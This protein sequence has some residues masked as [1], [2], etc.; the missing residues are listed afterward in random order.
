[1]QK[2]REPGRGGVGRPAM[3]IPSGKDGVRCHAPHV[4]R[5]RVPGSGPV[6]RRPEAGR[7]HPWQRRFTAFGGDP[8]DGVVCGESVGREAGNPSAMTRG[9]DAGCL[10]CRGLFPCAVNGCRNAL[11]RDS[12]RC[13]LRNSRRL[14]GV[15]GRRPGWAYFATQPVVVRSDPGSRNGPGPCGKKVAGVAGLEP[16]TSAVTGQR[17]NQLSYTPA[18][19]CSFY[20]A[21]PVV[22][23]NS[24]EMSA[25]GTI[26]R[27]CAT[28]LPDCDGATRW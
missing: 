27:R 26:R 10:P 14:S 1:M 13:G 2:R 6:G 24:P 18:K 8:K 20:R 22:Q 12:A 16:V 5:L 28:S 21:G 11:R 7:G 25:R 15:F 19:D 3:P 23:G 9:M 4:G 17:S